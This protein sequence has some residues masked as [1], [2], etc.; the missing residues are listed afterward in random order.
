VGLTKYE[1][2]KAWRARNKDKKREQDRR[3]RARHPDVL[4]ATSA[5]FRE[6]HVERLK[7]VEAERARR[8]RSIN[9]EGCQS[10]LERYRAKQEAIKVQEAGR[11]RPIKCELCDGDGRIV[12]DHCHQHGHFRGW[13][14]DRCNKV[15][16]LVKDQTPLLR[17]MAEY[18]E[19]PTDGHISPSE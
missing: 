8:N 4:A 9:P 3:Y 6:R 1:Y 16:G 7:P 18:L 13:I 11:P 15:L 2:V 19:P 14:C 10:S 17:K 5:R 12:F